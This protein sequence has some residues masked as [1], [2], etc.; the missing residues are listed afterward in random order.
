M[1]MK[2]IYLDKYYVSHNYFLKLKHKMIAYS[3]IGIPEGKELNELFKELK[4][5]N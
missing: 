1:L 4:N 2:H 5:F 3:N